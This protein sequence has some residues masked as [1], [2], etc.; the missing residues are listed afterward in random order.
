MSDER[1]QI[2]A[3]RHR[4]DE[5][6]DKSLF[7]TTVAHAATAD[8]ARAFVEEIRQEFPDAT[9]NCWAFAAG[10]PGDTNSVGMSDDGEPSG[11]AGRPMLNVLL[12]SS[13]GEVAVVVTRYFG[14]VKLGTG[15]LVRAYTG[16]VQHAL[17]ALPLQR[18]MI[19]KQL[20]VSVAY[21]E[22][23]VM[24]RIFPAFEVQVMAQDFAADVAFELVVP[25]DRLDGF[26]R[27][28]TERTHGRAEVDVVDAAKTDAP[29]RV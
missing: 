8:D 4:V 9:H 26:L 17:E 23:D 18:F 12:H 1:Y 27:E 14:G 24:L 5:T 25:D 19:M 22:V 11:T 6:I 28:V 7:I 10:K 15:G 13:V 2:P 16:C 20:L 29:V 3:T 21:A